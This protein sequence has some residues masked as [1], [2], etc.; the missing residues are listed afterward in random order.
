MLVMTVKQSLFALVAL[1]FSFQLSYAQQ[2]GGILGQQAPEIEVDEWMHIPDGEKA[3]TK[4]SLKGK[5][6]YMYCYQAWCPGCHSSGFPTLK[7]LS[8]EFKSDKEVEFIVVHTVF[9]GFST[10]TPAKWKQVA[11][12]HG[13]KHLRFAHSGLSSSPS[14]V[15][16][17]YKTR[18]TPWTVIIGKDGKVKFN[19]FHIKPENATELINQLKKD[20]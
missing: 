12:R 6:V 17:A 19:G 9:E 7:K 16:S 13:L 10:N 1:A 4:E 20:K 3:P 2:Q 8:E 5:V 18:G 11:E 15:M 14:K